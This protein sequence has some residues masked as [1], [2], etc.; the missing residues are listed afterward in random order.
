MTH[1]LDRRQLLTGS[2]A[3]LALATLPRTAAAQPTAINYWHHFTS[4]VEFDGM[5]AVLAAFAAKHPE[6]TV[7]QENIPNPEFMTKV[8]AAVVS[9]STPNTSQV[10]AERVA[11][12]V[13]MGA[14]VDL[15][16]RVNGWAGKA[17]YPDDRWSGIT[18]DGKIYG[19]PSF[20]FV[21]WMYY[22]KDWFD[23]A[24]ISVPTTYT[25]FFDAA[26][27]ITDRAKGRYGFALRGGPGGQKFI[28]DVL[29]AFGAPLVKNGEIGLDKAPAVEAITWYAS[30][31]KEGLVPPSAPNDGFRQLIEGFQTGQTA[32]LW[33]HTGSINDI[34]SALKP[35]VQ[36]GTATMPAGPAAHI[37]RVAYAYN[38]AMSAKNADASWTWVSFWAEPEAALTF[39]KITG[40]F[41]ASLA[42]S[43]NE[44]IV[45]NPIY[46]PAGKTLGFGQLPP[47]FAG[48]AGWSENVAL[49]AFQRVL[50][51]QATPEQA[52]D[53][54]IAGLENA[55]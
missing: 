20:A 3:A 33:H 41:P 24:G 5:N 25:E 53:E 17:D 45:G 14:V 19:V 27:K 34:S 21:D 46:A 39:L 50:I 44:L 48:L 36:F 35:G 51:G 52:V 12:L 38:G 26:K 1:R 37:A 6:I 16:D 49:P 2:G 43:K 40:Y 10:T 11:D 30:L 54:M 7:T 32:M 9:G 22:R 8:T 29:E 31:F 23:E 55:K 47:R 28:I 13:A 18:I 4:Q 42:L 15:S